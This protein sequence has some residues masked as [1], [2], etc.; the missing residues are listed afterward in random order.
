[1]PKAIGGKCVTPLTIDLLA[2]R[3]SVCLVCS[4]IQNSLVDRLLPIEKEGEGGYT[5]PLYGFWHHTPPN[6]T[7]SHF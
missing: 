2:C 3:Y 4:E 6:L 5:L 7:T 1:M